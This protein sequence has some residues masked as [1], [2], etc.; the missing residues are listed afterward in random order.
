MVAWGRRVVGIGSA[1]AAALLVIAAFVAAAGAEGRVGALD[2]T[3]GEA[4]IV[5]PELEKYGGASGMAVGP[6]GSIVVVEGHKVVRILPDGDVDSGFGDGG[7]VQIPAELD[8]LDFAVSDLLVD[9]ER[10]VLVSGTIEDPSQASGVAVILSSF[11]A[12]WAIV[13]RMTADGELDR[14]FGEGKGY[15]RGDY[16]MH[17]I[18]Y[19]PPSN[20]DIPSAGA[21][22]VEVDSLDRPLLLVTTA[23]LYSP[24]WGHSGFD[25][26]PRA[27][28][29]LTAAGAADS[30]FGG[31]DG[32]APLDRLA[33]SPEPFFALDA[34][35]QPVVGGGEGT[36][37]PH[38]GILFRLGADGSRLDGF[39]SDGARLYER[40]YFTVLAPT[41]AMLLRGIVRQA[42][43]K[44]APDG[45]PDR[46]FGKEGQVTLSPPA[47]HG[48]V[49]PVAVDAQGRTLVAGVLW[50]PEPPEPRQPKPQRHRT[51]RAFLQVSRLLPNGNLDRAFGKRGWIVTP[52]GPHYSLYLGQ[53]Y[54]DP[55][56]RLVV[57]GE[58][59]TSRR[60]SGFVLA[61]YLLND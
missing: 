35:D 15:V 2:P 1:I 57:L 58:V 45:D 52:I 51:R 61:R 39:G 53:A 22:M 59:T 46:N 50:L 54:L 42:V 30:T 7:E 48:Y 21:L 32:I 31:G 33:P 27:V 41:G 38:Q 23:G 44:V 19:G 12:S 24:C 9:S 28:V 8:G 6:D 17:P 56:G 13:L 5:G 16:G 43:L 60:G 10:R 55:Q 18:S 4:G 36:A 34:A 3:F 47:G 40:R 11:S 14:S 49:R 37:C 25:E 29:R 26:Y 20:G